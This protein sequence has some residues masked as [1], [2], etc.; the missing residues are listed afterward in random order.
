MLEEQLLVLSDIVIAELFHNGTLPAENSTDESDG[1]PKMATTTAEERSGGPKSRADGDVRMLL[2]RM[3][4]VTSEE[5]E[6]MLI[7]ERATLATVDDVAD[8][9]KS[10][11]HCLLCHFYSLNAH[12]FVF[13]HVTAL[14][15][16]LLC[17]SMSG[18]QPP[19]RMPKLQQHNPPLHGRRTRI[20]RG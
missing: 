17:C 4:K 6:R 15:V 2:L 12:H 11:H 1:G 19:D 9:G 5:G 3:R 20:P 8:V 13:S 14:L 18:W 10:S 16:S 7:V